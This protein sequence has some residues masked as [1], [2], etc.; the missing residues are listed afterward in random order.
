M[1]EKNNTWEL[2]DCPHEKDI[3][4]VKWVYKTKLNLDETIQKH[5]ARLIA[6]GYLQ[7][8]RIDYNETFSPI[9]QL[10]T[11]KALIVVATQKGWSIYQLD[12]KSTFLN[13]INHKA[14]S[15]KA[16]KTKC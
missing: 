4:R 8:L 7:Q 5:K 13:E 1:I 6:K 11:I 10:D 12:V 16:M 3:I 2:I 15:A 9:A 14:L